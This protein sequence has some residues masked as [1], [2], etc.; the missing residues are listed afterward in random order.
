MLLLYAETRLAPAL[1]LVDAAF[2][3]TV[4]AQL[5]APV[6]FRTEFLDLPPTQDVAYEQRLTDLL[7]L[8]YQGVH[9]DLI[10]VFAAR[11]LRVA[12]EHR[13]D[14]TPGVPIVFM[15]VDTPGDFDL[16]G[17]VT[18]VA[19]AIDS[20]ETLQGALRLQPETRRVV[21]VGGTSGIDHRWLAKVRTT[22]AGAPAQLELTYLTDLPIEAVTKEVAALRDGTIVIL[23]SFIRDSTGATSP[24]WRS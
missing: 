3:S 19:M 20:M 11:A 21:V 24:R 15:A 4:S 13:A 10:A 14:L 16:P 5:G 6:D 12:L 9:F 23:V 2:R 18:G 7:R 1:T 17:D 8:K 22:F